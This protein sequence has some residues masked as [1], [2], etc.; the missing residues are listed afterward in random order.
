MLKFNS[1]SPRYVAIGIYEVIDMHCSSQCY[2]GGNSCK[3][4]R[5]MQLL[6]QRMARKIFALCVFSPQ[7]NSLK[8]CVTRDNTSDETTIIFFF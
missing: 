7:M 8:S 2:V 5:R 6:M 1:L 3:Y 4:T